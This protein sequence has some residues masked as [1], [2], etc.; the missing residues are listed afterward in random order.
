[1]A[2]E[3]AADM[4]A[5]HWSLVGP[6]GEPLRTSVSSAKVLAVLDDKPSVKI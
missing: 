6:E 4:A 5:N 2:A 3:K 1:M